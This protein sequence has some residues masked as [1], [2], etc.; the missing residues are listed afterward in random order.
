MNVNRLMRPTA[1]FEAKKWNPE[2]HVEETR[3]QISAGRGWSRRGLVCIDEESPLAPF[4]CLS[5]TQQPHRS[6]F[7]NAP[8]KISF[9]TMPV[10][11]EEC[12]INVYAALSRPA[13]G[14][15][16]TKLVE[17]S[18]NNQV[19]QNEIVVDDERNDE[20][21]FAALSRCKSVKNIVSNIEHFHCN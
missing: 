21:V 2:L 20:S 8:R 7:D 15:A 19:P 1:A 13:A 17:K 6:S 14:N 18:K 11:L 9:K 16:I 5:R 12:D 10:K 4:H 3:K